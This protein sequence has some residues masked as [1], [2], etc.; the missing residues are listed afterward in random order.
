MTATGEADDAQS[1][2]CRDAFLAQLA[3]LSSMIDQARFVDR[4]TTARTSRTTTFVQTRGDFRTSDGQ[5]YRNTYERAGRM[6]RG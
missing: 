4:R 6:R 3:T 2:D 1:V 5:P